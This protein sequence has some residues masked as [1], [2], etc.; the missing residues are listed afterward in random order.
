MKKMSLWTAAQDPPDRA[1][2]CAGFSDLVISAAYLIYSRG[3]RFRE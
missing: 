2:L 1:A 3:F